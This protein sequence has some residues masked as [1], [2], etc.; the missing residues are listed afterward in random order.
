MVSPKLSTKHDATH[1]RLEASLLLC[2]ARTCINDKTAEQIK[3]LLKENINWDYL[4]RTAIWHGVMPLLYCSLNA[5]CPEAVPK[6][7]MDRLRDYFHL[8]ARRNLFLTRELLKLL[9]LFQAHE[10][11]AI[12]YK[13]L[14]LAASAYGNLALRQFCDLDIL[15]HRQDALRVKSLLLTQGYRLSQEQPSGAQ[16]A[17][18]FQ[19]ACEYN[20]VSNDGRVMVEPHWAL[21]RPKYCF[22]LDSE[23]LWERLETI[24]LAGTPVLTFQPQDMLLIVCMNGTKDR[25]ETLKQICDVAETIR[26]HQEIDW[27]RVIKQAGILG[28]ERMLKLSLFLASDLLG[29]PLPE[30]VWQRIDADPVVK[31]LAAQVREQLFVKVDNPPKFEESNFSLWDIRVRERWQDRVRYCF[32]LVF[33]PNEGDAALLPLPPSLYFIYY[34]LRP[35]RLV[36]RNGLIVLKRI[37]RW[38]N[39]KSFSNITR[40]AT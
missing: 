14:V 34:L 25:W 27:E 4:L 15:I 24:S 7:I 40:R 33:M 37:L 13:G 20:F 8:L 30:K 28:S 12:P 31:L 26:A 17:L 5:T 22:R 11:P 32:T 36:G 29:T 3:A 19:S 23:C 18:W 35:I 16:E 6:A 10:I 9:N 39:P 1:T 21:A 2:C 38:L